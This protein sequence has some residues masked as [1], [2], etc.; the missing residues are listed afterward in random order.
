VTTL[1][2]ADLTRLRDVGVFAERLIGESLWDHQ[3]EAA[4]SPARFRTIIAGRQV[5]KSRCLAVMALHRA[6]TTTGARVLILSAGEDSAKQLLGE[7]SQLATSSPWL[8]GSVAADD[9][10]KVVLSNGSV[11][12]CV[13]ASQRRVRGWAVDLLIL[14]EACFIA[15]DLWDAARYTILARPGSRVVLA[16]TPYGR[17]DHFAAQMYRLGVDA[18]PG[19]RQ[20]ALAVDSEP[21]GRSR[22][23]GA[24]ANYGSAAGVS[25]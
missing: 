5:G 2:S 3:L 19:L 22:A 20:L 13:P 7:V 1:G 4:T 17:Q 18:Q 14:D 16:S 23:G 8:G 10:A 15:Q 21:A 25:A 12:R 11:I 9:T 6:F 24:L